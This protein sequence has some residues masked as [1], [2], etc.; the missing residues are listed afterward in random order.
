MLTLYRYH[1]ALVM[2][3]KNESNRRGS[4]RTG[5]RLHAKDPPSLDGRTRWI[6]EETDISLLAE[7]MILV[8]IMIG[9]VKSRKLVLS[10]TR[11]LPLVQDDP[12][13]NCVIWVKDALN[14]LQVEKRAMGDSILDWETV[15]SETI[16]YV[17][18]KKAQ[19]RFVDGSGFDATRPAT[20]DL[21]QRKEIIR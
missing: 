1:W 7:T 21:L 4:S 15:R 14:A 18:T 20:W 8:R 3:P 5:I 17:E 6:Y 10:I 2:G 19:R 11:D 13:W 16:N 12:E 9:K